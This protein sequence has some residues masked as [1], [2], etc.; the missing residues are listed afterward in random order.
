MSP[1][2]MSSVAA[3]TKV[4]TRADKLENLIASIGKTDI[5]QLYIADDGEATNQKSEI[6]AGSY[7]VD[8]DI[9]DLKYD[10]GLGYGRKR[11]VKEINEDYLLIVD[12]DHEVPENVSILL[13]QLEAM[14]G[15]GGVG[16]NLIEPETGRFTQNAH[17]LTEEGNRI[18]R[19]IDPDK[20]NVEYVSG[21]PFIGFDFIPNAALFRAEC[22]DDYC[23]DENYVI[24]R[25]HID[26]YVGHMKRTD[27]KFGVCP[28][29][30]F[31]HYP[32]GGQEYL[33]NRHSSTKSRKSTE[34]FLNKWGYDAIDSRGRFW[35]DTHFERPIE[36]RLLEIYRGRGAAEIVREGIKRAI[37]IGRRTLST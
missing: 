35:F 10:A 25:E 15:V 18:V 33:K 26:F 19:Y 6:Y 17:D 4:F 1:D 30:I 32:G 24:D 20:K 23:W 36:E 11:I 37:D 2:T 21:H 9:L 22:L 28:E 16:G 27:W 5:D 8:I 31:R 3:G 13:K 7:D 12:T 14:E 34:Y 29:V